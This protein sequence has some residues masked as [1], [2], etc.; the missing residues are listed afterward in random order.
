MLELGNSRAKVSH[1]RTHLLETQALQVVPSTQTLRLVIKEEL[2]MRFRASFGAKVMYNDPTYDE[3]RLWISRLLAQL[4]LE[5][6]V[7]ISLDES[8]FK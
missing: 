6:A 4:Y 3:K 5:G 1:V 7:I 2:H 8:S